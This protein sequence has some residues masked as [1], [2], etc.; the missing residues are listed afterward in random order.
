MKKVIIHIIQTPD[1]RYSAESA[2]SDNDTNANILIQCALSF[3]KQAERARLEK[4]S[5]S[6]ILNPHTGRSAMSILK[7]DNEEQKN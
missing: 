7:T 3:A 2:I 5:D 1:G 4:E 6:K